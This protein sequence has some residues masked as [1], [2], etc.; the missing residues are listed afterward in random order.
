MT[1]YDLEPHPDFPIPFGRTVRVQLARNRDSI[2]LLYL[3]A[4]KLSKLVIPP[5]EKPHR[6]DELWRTTCFELFIRPRGERKYVEFNFSPS[7][8]WA[9]YAFDDY[10]AGM[11]SV[12]I[13]E[14]PLLPNAPGIWTDKDGEFILGTTIGLPPAD[15]D[16][17]LTAVIEE[18][19]GTK[20][21]WALAHAPG[22]P[23]F[24][25]PDCFIATL[26]APERP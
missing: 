14:T 17:A 16:V 8:Q 11:R 1:I 12:E 23:D 7:K 2:S 24:H 18:A 26:P 13:D 3:V 4:G 25:N 22:P 20:S 9:A 15:A 21:Y 6:T 5:E 19:D 10:R